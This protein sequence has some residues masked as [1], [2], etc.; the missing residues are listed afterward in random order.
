MVLTFQGLRGSSRIEFAITLTPVAE[1]AI[2][3]GLIP[4]DYDVPIFR[5]GN[6]WKPDFQQYLAGVSVLFRFLVEDSINTLSDGSEGEPHPV[7]LAIPIVLSPTS[8][9]GCQL[10][11]F[12]LRTIVR[13]IDNSFYLLTEF[14]IVIL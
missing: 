6:C 5:V 13:V 11:C 8:N 12:Y 10:A 4:F 2:V 14:Q 3:G 7:H 1:I 9:N